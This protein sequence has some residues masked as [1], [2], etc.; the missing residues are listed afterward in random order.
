MRNI[1]DWCISRQIWWGDRIPAWYDVEGN[2]YVGRSEDA[3]RARHGFGTDALRFTFAA[4]ATTGR[5]VKFDLGRIEG[6][7]NFCNKLWNA[8][9]YVLMNTEDQDCGQTGGELELSAADR[10][11]HAITHNFRRRRAAPAA[12]ARNRRRVAGRSRAFAAPESRRL[13]G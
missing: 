9:R 7:R 10:W 5:D 1:Q 4:L 3:V 11:I 2:V 13:C 8:S 6:Y 12:R